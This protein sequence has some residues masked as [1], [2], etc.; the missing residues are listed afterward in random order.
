MDSNNNTISDNVCNSDLYN[1]MTIGNSN[2]NTISDNTCSWNSINGI[3]IY[4]SSNNIVQHNTCNFNGKCGI[5]TYT[6][7]GGELFNNTCNNNNKSGI[8]VGTNYYYTSYSSYIN[9]TNN[10]CRR[11]NHHGIY[12]SNCQN[13]VL[14]GNTM[15]DS[16]LSVY[17]YDPVDLLSFIIDTSNTV[18]GKPIY[19]WKEIESRSV[20]SDAGQVILVGCIDVVVRDL[21]ISNTSTGIS[22]FYSSRILITNNTCEYNTVCGIRVDESERVNIT[23]NECRYNTCTNHSYDYYYYFDIVISGIILSDSSHCRIENNSC[24]F[25]MDHGI[26][27]SYSSNFNTI[28]RNN[29]DHNGKNGICLYGDGYNNIDNNSCNYN[30][31]D[32]VHDSSGYNMITDNICSGN[33]LAGINISYENSMIKNNRNY[34]NKYG[35]YLYSTY[36]NIIEGN[37]FDLNTKSGIYCKSSSDNTISNNSCNLND[38]NGIVLKKSGRNAFLNNSC[39]FNKASGLYLN[40][41]HNAITNNSFS[42]NNVSGIRIEYS[43]DGIVAFNEIFNNRGYG[44]DVLIEA[45]ANEIHHNIL[46]DNNNGGTQASDDGCMNVWR[47]NRRGNYWSDWTTP[48]AD[49]DYIVDDRYDLDGSADNFDIFPLAV[50]MVTPIASGGGDIVVEE[51][52]TVQFKGYLSY[53]NIKILNYTWAFTYDGREIELYGINPKFNF[54]KTGVYEVNLTVTDGDGNRAEDFLVVTVKEKREYGT[55]VTVILAAGIVALI[56]L[57]V[58]HKRKMKGRGES[59]P[60]KGQSGEKSE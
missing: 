29:C 43:D 2:N 15:W 22:V 56:A 50:K 1:G 39:N 10:T 55:I 42:W 48:D 46:I 31:A 18:N 6:P 12:L 28:S 25:N 33:S 7:V 38:E 14:S 52:K 57:S 5:F 59:P 27:T 60:V 41:D 30:D 51:G 47:R 19:F 58:I 32:G 9:L 35:I 17:A 49:G 16:G 20:P 24:N 44:I 21:K 13:I 23:Y 26:M 40:G 53:D 36:S 11:N 34:D 8:E 3:G 54:E 37:E 45:E 4:D